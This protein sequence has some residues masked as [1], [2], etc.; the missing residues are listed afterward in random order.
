MM[1]H[2]LQIL[3]ISELFQFHHYVRKNNIHGKVRQN[4]FATNVRNTFML[5][6]VLP[7]EAGTL[8]ITDESGTSV[9]FNTINNIA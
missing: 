6:M 9:P 2:N 8:E 5:A 4:Q 3:T 7:L 1:K